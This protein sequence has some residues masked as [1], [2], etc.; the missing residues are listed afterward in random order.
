MSMFRRAPIA[1]AIA[2]SS[3]PAWSQVKSNDDDTKKMQAAAV[4]D[5]KKYTVDETTIHITKVGP[6]V[7]PEDVPSPGGGIISVIPVLDDIINLGQKLWKIVDDNKPVVD[8]KTQYATALPKGASGWQDIGGW[9]VPE[10]T[11]YNLTAKNLY[12]IKVIDVQYE[13]L[14]TYGG[15]Y[16][17]TGKYLTAV[18]V[19]AP[20]VDVLWGYHFSM[21][22]S[23]P[24]TSIVNVGTSQ[25]PVAGMMV[26]LNWHIATP[27][28]DSQ[29]QGL[30][31]LQGDGAYKD[32]GGPSSE[33]L[34]KT[35]AK[36]AETSAV[37]PRFD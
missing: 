36:F 11:V 7:V 9:H 13:V 34:E 8:V 30:Y 31:F 5:P 25:N 26:T 15:S 32:V 16:N 19:A 21:D 28:K 33:S 35:K 24:D 10:G 37:A 22:T 4:A 1:L 23:I 18:T 3:V 2:L 12:G 29:G 27:I 6:G 20:K 17:G 14:R